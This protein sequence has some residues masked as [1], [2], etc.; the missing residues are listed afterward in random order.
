M[1]WTG[2]SR[3]V[4]G[5]VVQK[6]VVRR[7]GPVPRECLGEKAQGRTAAK[8]G[9]MEVCCRRKRRA[10]GCPS[11]RFA[12]VR[13]GSGVRQG[14]Q[15]SQSVSQTDVR[16]SVGYGYVP[17]DGDGSAKGRGDGE[18]QYGASHPVQSHQV[19]MGRR[20]GGRPPVWSGQ[21]GPASSLLSSVCVPAER[22]DGQAGSSKPEEGAK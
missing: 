10:G 3:G 21:A 1:G 18:M 15:V 20:H 5:G 17:G 19:Q 6:Q 11:A 7:L 13:S 8:P 16:Q 2:R 14:R 4:R 9:S 22:A 12:R